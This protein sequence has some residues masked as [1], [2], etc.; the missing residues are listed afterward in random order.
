MFLYYNSKLF[1]FKILRKSLDLSPAAEI[2]EEQEIIED[3]TDEKKEVEGEKKEDDEIVEEKKEKGEKS[4]D[5]V[6]QPTID[7]DEEKHEEL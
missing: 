2:E 7:I 4:E 5:E 1:Y 3:E 6:E